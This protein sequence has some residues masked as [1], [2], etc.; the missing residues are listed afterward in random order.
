M[1]ALP[2]AAR[3]FQSPLL[4]EDD[5]AAQQIATETKNGLVSKLVPPSEWDEIAVQ[6]RD[7][8]HE[9]TE[10]FNAQRWAPEQLDRVAFYKN[11]QLVSAAM[12][13]KMRF[14]V[15][16]SGL[17]V[18]KWG[19]LWRPANRPHDIN[20][21]HDTISALKQIY[22]IAGGYFLSFFPRADPDVS[23]LETSA[24]VQN[25]FHPGEELASPDRYF[26]NMDLSLEELRGSLSQKWRYNLKKAERNGLTAR[27][28]SGQDGFETFM[29]LYN[30]MM[31]RKAFHDT[32]AI[33]TL[34]ALMT[35]DEPALRPLI[36]IVYQDETPIAGGVVDVSGE[37][38]IYLYGAT[39]DRALPLKAGYV[40]HW[41]ISKHLIAD[42][43]VRWYDLGGADKDCHLHQF[44]RGFVGKLGRL[45]TTPRYHHFG[46]TLKARALGH[47]LYF[48]R[49]K[50]GEIAR[51]LH[52]F[53]NRKKPAQPLKA[54]R[55][56]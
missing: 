35:A 15:V 1:D 39:N 10:C 29:Q 45:S 42:P 40:M 47:A 49:R 27:F 46:A 22:A 20:V 26:V 19:P 54:E 6:F 34:Q 23:D 28:V 37:R 55:P 43:N 14:P 41:E 5:S 12:V 4:A 18:V 31:D 2:L 51:V 48:A 24:F 44:K 3:M 38:A 13:L 56:S 21:L 50:K 9:Q 11:G 16:G 8:L 52:D 30:A 7:V 25:G 33:N 32:S 36:L 53:R 17:A